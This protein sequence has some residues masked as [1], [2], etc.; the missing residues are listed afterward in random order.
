MSGAFFTLRSTSDAGLPCRALPCT[1]LLDGF[2]HRDLSGAVGGRSEEPTDFPGLSFST[3]D[4]F[5]SA[6]MPLSPGRSFGSNSSALA[7]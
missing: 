1:L 3:G 4:H 7:C 2:L 5:A 6:A